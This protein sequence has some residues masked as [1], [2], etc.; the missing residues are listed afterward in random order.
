MYKRFNRHEVFNVE[1]LINMKNTINDLIEKD[2]IFTELDNKVYGLYDGFLYDGIIEE[3]Y[4]VLDVDV[5]CNIIKTI[6]KV[7]DYIKINGEST[8]LV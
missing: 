7:I 8:T 6:N 3:L 5:F 1:D 2:M 4:Q